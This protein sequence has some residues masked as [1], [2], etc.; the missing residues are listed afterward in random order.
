MHKLKEREGK[1][2]S[3][4]EYYLSLYICAS[5]ELPTTKIEEKL[6]TLRWI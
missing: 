1:K 3:K 6:E 5:N 4:L 2:L